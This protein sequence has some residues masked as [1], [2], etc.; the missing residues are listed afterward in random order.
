MKCHNMFQC[1]NNPF[2]D[3]YLQ[4]HQE[5]LFIEITTINGE[6]PTCLTTLYPIICYVL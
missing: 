5:D 2:D 3:D 6:H 1:I 4:H